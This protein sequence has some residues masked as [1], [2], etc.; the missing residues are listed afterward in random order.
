MWPLRAWQEGGRRQESQ[1]QMDHLA[2]FAGVV[3]CGVGTA[4][5]HG[6]HRRDCEKSSLTANSERRAD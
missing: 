2:P 3:W 5:S 6:A 1:R 4:A